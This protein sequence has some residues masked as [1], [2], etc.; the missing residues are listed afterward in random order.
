MT[1]LE[2]IRAVA[3]FDGWIGTFS[4][5]LPPYLISLDAIVPVVLKLDRKNRQE[6]LIQLSL[7]VRND[8]EAGD[9]L[10]IWDNINATARQRCEAL[11]R[12][13]GKW[14]EDKQ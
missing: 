4:Y 8:P 7:I 13:I 14:R 10:F 9:D 11:L 2:I 3:E 12:T 6:F 5:E 1:D